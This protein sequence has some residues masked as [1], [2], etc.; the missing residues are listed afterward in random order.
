MIFHNSF[1][2]LLNVLR[3]GYASKHPYINV[4]Y[5]AKI[6]RLL[7]KLI[8]IR[9][10]SSYEILS[11]GMLRIYLLYDINN[12]SNFRYT[13]LLFK[14]SHRTHIS[15]KRLIILHKYDFGIIYILSTNSGLLTHTEAIHL[16]IG[17]ELICV[18]YS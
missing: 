9:Y 2:I 18:L 14:P 11:N 1:N 13:K 4:V 12:N 5:N 7:N 17:G 8:Q 3:V 16:R 10:V 6:L 15:Y